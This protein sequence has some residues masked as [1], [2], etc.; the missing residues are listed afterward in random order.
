[1][2]LYATG[3]YNLTPKS[4]AFVNLV[5]PPYESS[6]EVAESANAESN[7]DHII[8]NGNVQS[9]F[10][11]TRCNKTYEPAGVAKNGNKKYRASDHYAVIAYC[12]NAYR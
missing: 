12:S 1:M 4:N 6:R 9:C 3:D 7:I 5:R 10:K 8:I 2:P 11:Y